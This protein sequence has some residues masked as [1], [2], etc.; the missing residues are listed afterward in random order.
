[1][2]IKYKNKAVYKYTKQRHKPELRRWFKL[3]CKRTQ[4]AAE[5]EGDTLINAKTGP[6]QS[7]FGVNMT[8]GL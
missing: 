5:T 2:K 3:S 6:L 7:T 1:M 4:S 8:A